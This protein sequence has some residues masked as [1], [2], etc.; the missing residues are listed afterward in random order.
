MSEAFVPFPKIPRLNREIV[1]TEKLDGTN[2]SVLIGGEPT[3]ALCYVDGVPVRA[4]SRNRWLTRER[5]NFGFAAWVFENAAGLVA[6]L[7]EG[8]HFGEWWGPGINRG[9]GVAEKRFSLFNVSKW[10]GIEGRV[11]RLGVVPKLYEGPWFVEPPG[12]YVANTVKRWAPAAALERLRREG[13]VASPGFMRP[14]GIVVFHTAGGV[15]FKA[16]VEGDE[17]PKGIAA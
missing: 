14:E 1:I 17:K 12:E 11:S 13:S 4:G 10:A 5:D 2:A 3:D 15:L 6:A 9:Y 7:G 8:R 16:T